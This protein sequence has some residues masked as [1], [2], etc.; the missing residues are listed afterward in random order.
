MPC[1]VAVRRWRKRKASPLFRPKANLRGRF[2]GAHSTLKK[3]RTGTAVFQYL[4][5]PFGAIPL[6]PP[7]TA[8]PTNIHT[9]YRILPRLLQPP[10]GALILWIQQPVTDSISRASLAQQR[11]VCAQAH[12]SPSRLGPSTSWTSLVQ[13]ILQQSRPLFAATLRE[14]VDTGMI[15][16]IPSFGSK[17]S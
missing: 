3:A 12:L 16:L 10:R 17:P 14:G 8:P 9:I 4:V 1:E 7:S 6:Q 15:V 13:H 5:L 2:Y 11:K